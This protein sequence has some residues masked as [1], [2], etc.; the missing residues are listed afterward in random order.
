M[1]SKMII[2]GVGYIGSL[3]VL[4]SFLMVSVVKLRIVNSIGSFIFFVYALIIKSYPTAIMNFCLVLINLHHL[5]RMRTPETKTYDLIKADP[6]DAFLK[7]MIEKYKSD[8]LACFPG[9][10]TEPKPSSD[11]YIVCCD[12][13]LAGITFGEMKGGTY[14]IELDYTTPAYRDSSVGAFLT[15]QL[16]KE[17]VKE[18]RYNG[19]AENHTAYLEKLGYQKQ[20]GAYVRKL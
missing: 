16:A 14:D 19:P 13:A 2:E 1:N 9:I 4:V 18:L 11:A 12:N 6:R 10:N 15:Q 5:R 8:I 20:D 3:L 17:G 7:H